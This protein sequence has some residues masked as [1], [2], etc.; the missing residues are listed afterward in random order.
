[1]DVIP[2]CPILLV[3]AKYDSFDVD[4]VSSQ[5]SRR[6]NIQIEILDA[7]HG[8]IDTYSKTILMLKQKFLILKKKTFYLN[9]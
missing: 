3:F 1:M 5:L 8:F 7:N 2:T 6:Q 4:Y 9:V